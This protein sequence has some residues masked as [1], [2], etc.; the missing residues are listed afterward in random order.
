MAAYLRGW[1]DSLVIQFTD[2]MLTIPQFELLVVLAVYVRLDS[3]VMRRGVGYVFQEHRLFPHLSVRNNLLF[4]PR[5]CGRPY[6]QSFFERVVTQIG[7]A[8]V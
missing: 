4:A 1:V 6:S 3:P 5:F 7:R 2:F 8:H